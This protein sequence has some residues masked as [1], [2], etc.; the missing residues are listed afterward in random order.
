MTAYLLV[1]GLLEL[2]LEV[3]DSVENGWVLGHE[4]EVWLGEGLG[5]EVLCIG[6][7]GSN[8]LNRLLG[9]RVVCLRGH[10]GL[11]EGLR[12]ERHHGRTGSEIFGSGAN[13]C[14]YL[15]NSDGFV[16]FGEGGEERGNGEEIR[17]RDDDTHEMA[18]E[19]RRSVGEQLTT[20]RCTL[21]VG[22]RLQ[23]QATATAQ[24]CRS[25]CDCQHSV[26]VTRL[27]LRL[28]GSGQLESATR[29]LILSDE[30]SDRPDL[31]IWCQRGPRCP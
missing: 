16:C 21:G 11:L 18:T 24:R 30:L 20:E 12:S 13:H 27:S 25:G 28:G 31:V 26:Q 5:L 23:L 19:G 17:G 29:Y 22:Y 6:P 4:L 3:T 10:H 9:G 15:G 8:R 1:A 2:L 7:V 14:V